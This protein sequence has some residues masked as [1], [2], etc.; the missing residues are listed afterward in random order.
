M[1]DEEAN[2]QLKDAE[3]QCLDA[4]AGYLLKNSIVANVIQADPLLKAIHSG[5]NANALE[6]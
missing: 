2:V 4:R 1:S 6:R 5:Q 3:R